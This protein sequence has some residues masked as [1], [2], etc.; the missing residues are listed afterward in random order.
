MPDSGV[1]IVAL[2]EAVSTLIDPKDGVFTAA[3]TLST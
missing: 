1:A 2:L 3:K